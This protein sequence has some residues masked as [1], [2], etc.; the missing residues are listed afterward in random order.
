MIV[1][2]KTSKQVV[3][4]WAKL[5][6]EFDL[7]KSHICNRAGV[8]NSIYSYARKRGKKGLPLNEDHVAKIQ[9][10]IEALIEEQKTEVTTA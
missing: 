2:M 9:G 1:D 3:A 10:A 6:E 7:K 4:Q 5:I 8:Q